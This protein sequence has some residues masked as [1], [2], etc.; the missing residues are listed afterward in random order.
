MVQPVTLR[1]FREL[2]SLRTELFDSP[3]LSGKQAPGCT[4]SMSVGLPSKKNAG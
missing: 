2:N 4:S 1:L 3:E